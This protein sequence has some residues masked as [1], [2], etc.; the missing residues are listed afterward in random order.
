M[1]WTTTSQGPSGGFWRGLAKTAVTGAATAFGGPIAGAAGGMVADKIF[2]IP[3]PGKTGGALGSDARAYMDQAYPGTNPWERLGAPGYNAA[4]VESAKQT[5]RVQQK[6]QARQLG[7]QVQVAQIAAGAH[8]EAA[9]TSVAPAAMKA[10]A[11]MALIKQ[12][13]LLS[14]AKTAMEGSRAELEGAL[15]KLKTDFAF[16]RL[17]A[18]QTKNYTATIINAMRDYE[19]GKYKT[20]GALLIKGGATGMFGAFA[21]KIPLIKKFFESFGAP[22]KFKRMPVKPGGTPLS[23]FSKNVKGKQRQRKQAKAA[24]RRQKRAKK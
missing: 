21:Q 5:G 3:N 14:I 24:L 9:R 16:A 2:G 13:R 8:V 17:T 4:G 15:A 1:G 12:E 11:E 22:S 19:Q 7:T 18:E 10:P 6:M 23:A 20:G